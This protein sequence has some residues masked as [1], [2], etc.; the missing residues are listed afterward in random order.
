VMRVRDVL[1]DT[2]ADESLAHK[3]IID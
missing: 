1:G 2:A 3:A